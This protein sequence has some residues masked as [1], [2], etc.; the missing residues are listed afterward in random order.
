MTQAILNYTGQEQYSVGEISRRLLQETMSSGSSSSSS[1]SEDAGPRMNRDILQELEECVAMEQQLLEKLQQ[2][3]Q[4][5]TK[6]Q[7]QQ[8]WPNQS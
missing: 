8:Q 4:Q 3:Q 6:L 1:D 7:Q 2:L 5:Q